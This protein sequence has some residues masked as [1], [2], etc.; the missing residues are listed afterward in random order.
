MTFAL[1][2]VDWHD[3]DQQCSI[4]IGMTVQCSAPYQL[5]MCMT[6]WAYLYDTQFLCHN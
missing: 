6:L 3:L 5:E 2:L 4:G 1:Q